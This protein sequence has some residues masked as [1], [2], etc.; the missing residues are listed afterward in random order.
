MGYR[1]VENVSKDLGQLKSTGM[2]SPGVMTPA[3][4]VGDGLDALTKLPGVVAAEMILDCLCVV[5]FCFPDA[6]LQV[7]A[8]STV[9]GSVA[10]LEGRVISQEKHANLARH[11]GFVVEIYSDDFHHSGVPNAVLHVI[12][13]S[14]Q[15]MW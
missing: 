8:G 6:P 11:P 1:Q 4:V 13:Y 3:Y 5:C 14:P 15:A 10:T 9:E 2:K 12:Q 7:G